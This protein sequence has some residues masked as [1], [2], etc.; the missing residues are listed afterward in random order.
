MFSLFVFF[1][2]C[3]TSQKPRIRLVGDV[4]PRRLRYQQLGKSSEERPSRTTETA[5]A[6]AHRGHESCIFIVFNYL[7]QVTKPSI[8]LPPSPPTPPHP[9]HRLLS[10]PKSQP[11]RKSQATRVSSSPG[12][13]LQP[14]SQKRLTHGNTQGKYLTQHTERVVLWQ[15][16]SPSGFPGASCNRDSTLMFSINSKEIERFFIHALEDFPRNVS[17]TKV[18]FSHES[19]R[20]IRTCAPTPELCGRVSLRLGC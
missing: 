17:S 18:T 13:Q 15:F 5:E 10:S 8:T 14:P 12:S 1:F 2:V 3:T 16:R 6:D 19:R 4:K 9:G 20:A 11:R 7:G